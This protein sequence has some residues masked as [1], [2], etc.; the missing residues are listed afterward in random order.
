MKGHMTAP[1]RLT[2]RVVPTAPI[3]AST[4]SP[5]L[6]SD[7]TERT[8]DAVL[9]RLADGPAGHVLQ[10]YFKRGKM[11][12]ASLVFAASASVGGDPKNVVVAAEAIELLHGASLFHDDIVDRATERRGLVS[13][14]EQLGMGQALVL[15][16]DLLLRAFAVLAEARAYHPAA[17]VLEAT[18]VLIQF[19]REC[20]RGQFEELAAGRW[21]S[22]ESYL[23]I[24]RG[25]TAAP[26]VA[27]G[28]LGVLLGGGNAAQIT[29]IR[30]YAEHLG[31]AFQIGDDLL[32]LMGEAAGIGKPVGNSLA[33]GRPMLPLIY[34]WRTSAEAMQERLSDLTDGDGGREQLVALLAERGILDRVR[35]LQQQHVDAALAAID[36]FPVAAGVEALRALTARAT[37]PFPAA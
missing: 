14:H 2:S 1:T 17:L 33:H 15:G 27:A 23:T 12:R 13:L 6:F 30:A 24:V 4:A 28:V 26:F 37:L 18:E 21:I 29:R 3:A 9:A 7:Y 16:D 19:A 31:I 34:L 32:D 35:H 25:K 8:R 10:E 36:A 5:V 11:L 20:C 22:E